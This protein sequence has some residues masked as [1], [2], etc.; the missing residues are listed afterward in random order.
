MLG[1]GGCATGEIFGGIFWAAKSRA[2]RALFL[3]NVRLVPTPTASVRPH[4]PPNRFAT[5]STANAPA[6][7]PFKSGPAALEPSRP[8]KRSPAVPGT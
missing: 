5:A 7:Q 3:F 2:F 1:W 6:L 8:V 4:R